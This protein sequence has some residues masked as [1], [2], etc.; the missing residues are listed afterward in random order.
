[1][2]KRFVLNIFRASA[3]NVPC[4]D[5]ASARGRCGPIGRFAS[6]YPHDARRFKDRAMTRSWSEGGARAE[7]YRRFPPPVVETTN[8]CGTALRHN[9]FYRRK[10]KT[11]ERRQVAKPEWTK[12]PDMRTRQTRAA[13]SAVPNERLRR[14]IGAG[15]HHNTRRTAQREAPPARRFARKAARRQRR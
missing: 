8:A 4:D 6:V 15:Y 10:Y 3:F 2:I 11:F 14:S 5:N 1:M 13:P 9:D 12:I 7:C